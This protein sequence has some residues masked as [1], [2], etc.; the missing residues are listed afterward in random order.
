MRKETE[1]RDSRLQKSISVGN[2]LIILVFSL[3]LILEWFP[4][5]VA[6]VLS[7]LIWLLFAGV[8]TEIAIKW[9]HKAMRLNKGEPLHHSCWN[10]GLRF[11]SDKSHCPKC[12][13]LFNQEL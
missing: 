11:S 10:C 12:N 9:K 7:I 1:D 5:W 6:I 13:T 2:I 8:L 3:S 4:I